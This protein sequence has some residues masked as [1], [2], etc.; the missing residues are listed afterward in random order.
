VR[1][2]LDPA[3]LQSQVLNAVRDNVLKTDNRADLEAKLTGLIYNMSVFMCFTTLRHSCYYLAHPDLSL[4]YPD[5]LRVESRKDEDLSFR[6][7]YAGLHFEMRSP[8]IAFIRKMY[9]DLPP[10]GKDL[11]HMWTWLFL[12][13][14]K[15]TASKRQG[16]LEAANMA[17]NV[18]LLL[19]RGLD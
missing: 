8:D 18:Q 11:L 5:V 16:L 19:P 2:I 10:G 13:F 17:A 3:A 14:N 1:G 9:P 7:L 12:S 4:I 15:V 6:L